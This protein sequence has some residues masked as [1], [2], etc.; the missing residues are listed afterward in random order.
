VLFFAAI[1]SVRLA[2]LVEIVIGSLV[3]CLELFVLERDLPS[4]VAFIFSAIAMVGAGMTRVFF[5]PWQSKLSTYGPAIRSSSGG[6]DESARHRTELFTEEEELNDIPRLSRIMILVGCFVVLIPAIAS[7]LAPVGV[8]RHG[9]SLAIVAFA[10]IVLCARST[11]WLPSL[12]PV[13]V[14]TPGGVSIA[15]PFRT[16]MVEMMDVRLV[17]ANGTLFRHIGL[18]LGA[19]FRGDDCVWTGLMDRAT[20][21]WFLRVHDLREVKLPN[22]GA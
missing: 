15:S 4:G 3:V 5:S 6:S 13:V 1:S 16:C 8:P 18:V 2:V 14:A 20:W 12:A 9:G 21:D 19:I 7:A 22:N 17:S 10:W 11:N